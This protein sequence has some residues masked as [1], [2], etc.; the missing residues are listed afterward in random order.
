MADEKLP[1]NF[2]GE[3]KRR[4]PKLIAQSKQKKQL[5]CEQYVFYIPV[6]IP[7]THKIANG[8][9]YDVSRC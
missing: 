6:P 8:V 3:A 9:L 4:H 5:T 2:R 7:C 1:S